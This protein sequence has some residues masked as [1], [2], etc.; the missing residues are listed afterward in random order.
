ML[1]APSLSVVTV[2]FEAEVPLLLLQARSLRRYAAPDSIDRIIV[3]DHTRRG[4]GRRRCRAL[5]RAYGPLADR[6]R[7]VRPEELTV[8]PPG[9]TGWVG[10]QVLKLM[11]HRVVPSTH[12]LVL[13]AKNHWIEPTGT[14]T[15][16]NDDGR[17]RGASHSFRSHPLAGNVVR[18]LEY[19]GVPPDGWL[20]HF[21][22]THTPVVLETAVAAHLTE[23]LGAR[24][25]HGFAF[26]FTS[27]GL[28]E[29]PLYAGWII[30]TEGTLEKHIDG[31]VVRSTTIWPTS[32]PAQVAAALAATEHQSSPFLAVHRRALARATPEL[33]SVLT[34]FWWRRGL[35]TSRWAG[36]A[37][38]WR[39]KVHYAVTMSVRELNRRRQRHR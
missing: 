39:F 11:A 7:L 2:V 14:H 37:F 1:P 13:D 15:F 26:E 36:R 8:L 29:F 25:E 9:T 24:H 27:Q 6:L 23:E 30:A 33:A 35:F 34:E 18:V 38:V 3:V 10:Q 16:L 17:A 20:D 22:V 4:L 12:Y 32:T 28:T 19:L 21:P 5:R 31:T